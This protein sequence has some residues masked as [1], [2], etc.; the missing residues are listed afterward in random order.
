M[1]VYGDKNKILIEAEKDEKLVLL[2]M[3]GAIQV[4]SV[5]RRKRKN[6]CMQGK[7][8]AKFTKDSQFVN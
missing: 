4:E 1:K 2:E 6:K 3:D 5:K 7:P 8:S